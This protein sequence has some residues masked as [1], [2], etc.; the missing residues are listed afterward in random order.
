MDR[1]TY[2]RTYGLT[3]ETHFIRSTQKSQPKN[4][5]TNMSHLISEKQ[6]LLHQKSTTIKPLM[7]ACPLFREFCE[8]NKAAK[9][10]AVNT[11]IIP[12]LIHILL[13]VGIASLEFTKI[14]GADIIL[15]V[16]SS[17]FRA[18]KLKGFTVMRFSM[19]NT[20]L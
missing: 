4:E 13:S 6:N 8:L 12:S 1:R 19:T 16:K 14:R 15:H 18:T 2:V 20:F 5:A 7:F 17:T 3:L 9:L 11:D 10:K